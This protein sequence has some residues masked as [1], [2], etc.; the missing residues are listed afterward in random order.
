M[1][2]L[3]EQFLTPEER[4]TVTAAVQTAEK[5]TSGEIVP[6]IVSES[7]SYPV[8]PIVGGV[9]FALPTALLSARL[10]GG[11]LWLGTDNM[12]LFLFFFAIYYG[13]G[14]F[15]VKRIP[16]LKRFFFSPI[17]ADLAVQEA[18]AAA[19]FS[20]ALYDTRD[21]NGILLYISV[22]EQRVWV[23][24]DRGIDDKIDP[25]TWQKIVDLVS[26]GIKQ[27]S[28]CQAICDGIERIGEILEQHFPIKADDK[29]ELHNLIIR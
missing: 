2:T 17:R 26:Q 23:L 6:M 12:W 19:F 25:Q 20:E 28:P 24:G 1:T 9:F 4:Q 11:L 16:R 5:R 8:A 18:A 27:G 10:C 7:H 21:A 22:F 13:I 3:A 29:N 14:Y 15:S